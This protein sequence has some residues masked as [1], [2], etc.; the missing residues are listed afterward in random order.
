[1]Q[2]MLSF[3]LS[4]YCNVSLYGVSHFGVFQP[5]PKSRTGNI[6]TV[7]NRQME[8]FAAKQTQ[9]ALANLASK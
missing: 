2:P 8:G 4:R 1:M 6:L 7:N 3:S 9:P 5:S